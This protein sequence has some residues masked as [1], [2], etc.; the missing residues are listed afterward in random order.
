MSRLPAVLCVVLVLSLVAPASVAVAQSNGETVTLTV[1]VRD[2]AGN[3][4]SDADLDVTWD[5]GSTTATTAANGKAFVDVP[6]GAS[7]SIAVTHP[8]YVRNSPY[9]IAEATEDDV[10]VDVFRKSSVRLEVSDDDGPVANASVLIERGGL[11]VETGT[12]GP[13]GVFES[14]VLQAGS[15]S[16]TVSKAGYYTRR[17][18]LDIDGEI[19]NRVAL[20]RGSTAVDVRVVDPHFDP[21]RPVAGA[22]VTLVGVGGSRTDRGGNAS[23]TAPVNTETTLRVTRDGYRTVERDLTVGEEAT[24]VSVDLSRTPSIT[25]A[26]ANERIVAGERLVITATNAYGEPSTDATIYLDGERAGTTDG[27]GEAAVRIDDPGDHTLYVTRNGVRSNEVSVEAISA[28][29]DTATPTPSPTATP[30]PTATTTTGTS[31]GF[32]AVLA[33][34]ATLLFAARF[35]RR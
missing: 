1:T 22:N 12:T 28:D 10:T 18:S 26:A 8:R 19:T 34:L 11:D 27:E 13:N 33:V 31:P 23:V 29:G 21:A 14:G 16:I 24:T 2:Q 3:P 35:V 20:R 17:K 32:G 7:V 4:I 15:Y 9:R 30:T 5:G 25:L 6:A